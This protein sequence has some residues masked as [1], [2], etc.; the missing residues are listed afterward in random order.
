MSFRE[1]IFALCLLALGAGALGVAFLGDHGTREVR[2]LKAERQELSTEIARLREKNAAM[3]RE[4]A[5][6][7]ENPKAIEARARRELG[8]IRNGETVFLLPGPD[9][10][11]R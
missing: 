10:R 1:K 3:E 7:R 4:I 9:G 8:M 2:R 11:R 6:L 5:D